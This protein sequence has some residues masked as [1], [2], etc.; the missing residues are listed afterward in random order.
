MWTILELFVL[1]LTLNMGGNV[2]GVIFLL[3]QEM[4]LCIWMVHDIKPLIE[5]QSMVLRVVQILQ[6][7]KKQ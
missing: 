4:K 7:H 3:G 5:I 1:L 2:G 6:K